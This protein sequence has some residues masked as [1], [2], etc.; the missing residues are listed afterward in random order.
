[1]VMTAYRVLHPGTGR[2][3]ILNLTEPLSMWGGLDPESGR[4]VDRSH[5][6]AGLSVS[7]RILV[8]SHGRGS[9]SSSSVLAESLR[10]GTGPAGMI[11]AQIDPILVTGA[12]VAALLYQTVCPVLCGPGPDME[13]VEIAA[14]GQVRALES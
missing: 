14:N 5:P 7:G 8:M 11:L 2:G 1:M 3:M 12:Y 13:T 9:S 10:L 6:Q 4:I